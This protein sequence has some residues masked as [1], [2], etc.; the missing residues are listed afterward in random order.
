MAS[1]ERK[2]AENVD[3]VLQRVDPAKRAFLKGLLVGSAFVTPIV[4][5]FS[6]SGVSVYQAHAQNGSNVTGSWSASLA[7]AAIHFSAGFGDAGAAG[8]ARRPRHQANRTAS[9][10]NPPGTPMGQ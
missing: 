10:A 7:I 4:T 5:S 8:L 1:E 2:K 9:V 6:M 3:E